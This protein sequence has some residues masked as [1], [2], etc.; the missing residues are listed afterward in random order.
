MRFAAA[1]RTTVAYYVLLL[2]ACVAAVAPVL[3]SGTVPAFQQDW[4]WPLA[5]PQAMQWMH[6]FIGLWDVR[7]LGHA[8]ALPWQ[9]YVVATQTASVLVFGPSAGL[10]VWLGAVLFA[11]ASLS[12]W[13]LREFGVRTHVA[14]FAG[15]LFYATTPVVF[16]RVAAGHLAYLVAYAL[17]PAVVVLARRTLERRRWTAAVTLGVAIGFT[18][19]QIQFLAIAWLAIVPLAFFA[20][21]AEGWAAR[22]GAALGISAAVQLQ[23]LLPLALGSTAA[24]YA[25][26]R[27]LLSFEYNNSSPL[28]GALV[29]LGYFTHY[30]EAAA[31]PWAYASLCALVAMAVVL[32]IFASRRFGSFALV[33]FLGG[34]VLSAGL[35]GPLSAPLAWAF[36]RAAFFTVFRDLHYFAVL[37]AL[38]VALAIGLA[39]ERFRVAAVP[40]LAAIVWTALPVLAGNDLRGLL[41]PSHYLTETVEQMQFVHGRGDG[42]VLWLPAEEPL[43]ITGAPNVGRDFTAYGA[44]GNSSV[45]DDLDNPQLSYALATLRDGRPDWNAFASLGIRYLVY[46]SYVRS[47]RVL[48]NLGTGFRLAYGAVDDAALGTLLAGDRRLV[49]IRRYGDSTVYELSGALADV[50]A[51]TADPNALLYSELRG[52]VVAVAQSR[53]DVVNAAPSLLTADPRLAWVEGRIGWRYRAWLADSIYPFVWTVSKQTLAFSVPQSARCLLAGSVPPALLQIASVTSVVD[54]P[55]RRSP[56]GSQRES[57]AGRIVGSGGVTAIGSQACGQEASREPVF[58]MASGYDSGWREVDGVAL[59]GP[60]LANGW[61]MAW[62]QRYGA[63]PRIYLPAIA[64]F[65]GLIAG[66][67]AIAASYLLARRND[68]QEVP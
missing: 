29:M 12:T 51:A 49:P 10:A 45:S 56:V 6:S 63:D 41:V 60:A 67:A 65:I 1:V 8:N 53:A 24:T 21:R 5:R 13:M 55:W 42:R 52:D 28:G 22:L 39:I 37:T 32:G 19:S 16:T 2:A 15:A 44:P 48:D 38:G 4:T 7:S 64:Q 3:F 23:C 43:G 25:A 62:P 47:A 57:P 50:R 11:A 17:L 27:A 9:S 54:G 66:W 18:A 30:Y 40:L 61:M 46:R 35:Y 33:L 59:V 26:Q 68:A 14:L 58:V 36:D 34:V 20:A 31:P